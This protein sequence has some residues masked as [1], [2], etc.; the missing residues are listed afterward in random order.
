M[1]KNESVFTARQLRSR[2]P[3][4]RA[5]AGRLTIQQQSSLK[6]HWVS[7]IQIHQNLLTQRESNQSCSWLVGKM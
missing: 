7:E 6:I 4:A 1:V 3:A 2:S 5:L